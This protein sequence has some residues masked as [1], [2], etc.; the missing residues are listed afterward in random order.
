[1]P[2]PDEQPQQSMSTTH[3]SPPDERPQQSMSTTHASPPAS[4]PALPE[5]L[6]LRTGRKVL[7]H[8][9]CAPCSGAMVE[10]MVTA[11]HDV[12]IFFYNPNIH[13][14]KEYELRIGSMIA[15]EDTLTGPNEP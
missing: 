4:P 14:R 11:G 13:P 9:C 8:S 5:H 7:L 15:L 6:G 2:A 12:T 3:A 10:A 1:M